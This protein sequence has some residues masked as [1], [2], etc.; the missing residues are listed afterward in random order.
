MPTS[1]AAASRADKADTA[2]LA[3]IANRIADSLGNKAM[4]QHR[5][6][7]AAWSKEAG[8]GAGGQSFIWLKE[9]A[10]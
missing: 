1:W 10:R 3:E 7:W 5:Q 6:A 4:R 2:L 9:P 8:A